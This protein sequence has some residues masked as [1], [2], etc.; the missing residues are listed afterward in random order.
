MKCLNSQVLERPLGPG[1]IK[2]LVV[3]AGTSSTK[4]FLLYKFIL[5]IFTS[6][7]AS[8]LSEAPSPS[9]SCKPSSLGG[10]LAIKRECNSLDN[11]LFIVAG[12]GH[13]WGSRKA[14]SRPGSLTI[15]A[16]CGAWLQESY[17]A[18]ATVSHMPPQSALEI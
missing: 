11:T 10:R 6:A 15:T 13:L 5:H 4:G 14:I 17:V 12:I 2:P 1:I 8:G 16:A 18:S 3:S 7:S 9:T